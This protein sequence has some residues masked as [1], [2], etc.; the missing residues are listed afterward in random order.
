M[1]R[2]TFSRFHGALTLSAA[3]VLTMASA[4]SQA[5]D[6]DDATVG[7]AQAVPETQ[8]NAN[9]VAVNTEASLIEWVGTKVT[10][11]HNGTLHIS[12][13]ALDLA[14]GGIAG[15]S[16]TID[17]NSLAVS[18][19]A[20]EKLRGHLASGDFFNIAEFPTATFVLTGAEAFEG[21]VEDE[22][23]EAISQ[24]KVADPT[25]TISGNLTMLGV[26]KG[27][28]FPAKVTLTEGGVDAMAK[29][30]INRKDWGVN[31]AGKKDDLIRDD[32]HLGIHLVAGDAHSDDS[33][34]HE[35]DGHDHSDEAHA[36]ADHGEGH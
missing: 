20:G 10:G 7:D 1:L 21:E 12:E 33:D 23:V 14:D 16:F 30:N 31:Y 27:I 13:G 2:K 15:G 19:G 11:S 9:E 6:S 32:V 4:C 8:A 34:H 26:T 36:D 5:P 18:D 29:F 35:G 24:Y 25:H 28:S 22:E 17:M 3:L